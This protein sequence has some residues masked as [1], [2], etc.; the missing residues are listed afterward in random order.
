M[1]Y[2]LESKR[3]P[4]LQHLS[5]RCRTANQVLWFHFEIGS[6]ARGVTD[7]G[8]GSGALFGALPFLFGEEGA[9]RQ[10]FFRRRVSPLVLENLGH[11]LFWATHALG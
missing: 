5:G 6:I 9:I 4:A 11:L 1:S 8:V 2:G 10:L 3:L 7:I